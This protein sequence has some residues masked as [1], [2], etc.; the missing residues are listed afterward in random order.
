MSKLIL[1]MQMS[2]DGYMAADEDVGWQV[3]DWSDPWT[4]DKRLKQRFNAVF[5]TVDCILLS[6]KMAE[7]GYL[8]HWERVARDHAGDPDYAFA[9]EVV[10]SRKVVLTDKLQRSRWERTVI[11]RDGIV[12]EVSALKIATD[13]NIIAFGGVGFASALV[14]ASLVDEFQL[15]VNPTAVG[16]GRSIFDTRSGGLQLQLQLL[17]SAAYDC[18]IV[19]NR[20]APAV[21]R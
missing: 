19:V 13:R 17:D 21:N 18:G 5:E 9:R 3:W 14:A 8:D 7:Q 15:F 16:A 11:A 6:R 20:Y 12:K 4:W 1:Q 2:V 10:Q